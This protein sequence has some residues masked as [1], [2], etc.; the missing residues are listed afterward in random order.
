[1]LTIPKENFDNNNDNN[2]SI[3]SEHVVS[4]TNAGN[5][6]VDVGCYLLTS[7]SS[8]KPSHHQQ[9]VQLGKFELRVD[10]ALLSLAPRS[11][12]KQSTRL[13]LMRRNMLLAN[14]NIKQDIAAAS[15]TSSQVDVVDMD[16]VFLTLEINPSGFKHQ[17]PIKFM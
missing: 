7:S 3:I 17:I 14:K 8:K 9:F 5:I 12:S 16:N 13:L 6:P 10:E 2:S 1:M 15:N 11:I 4:I